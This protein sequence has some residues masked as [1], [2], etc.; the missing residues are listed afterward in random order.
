MTVTMELEDQTALDATDVRAALTAQM[1]AD[2]VVVY[3]VHDNGA[4]LVVGFR[5]GRGVC[6]WDLCSDEAAV[7]SGGNNEDAL[8]Y[9]RAQIAVPPGSEVD[10]AAV[11][12]A[13]TEFVA[14]GERP[15]V[16]EWQ[17]YDEAEFP[18]AEP[19]ITPEAL[20]EL[21]SKSGGPGSAG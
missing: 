6:L 2:H 11:L 19:T 7:T 5:G 8:M 16:V 18:V 9:G 13:A 1:S 20:Q 21:L 10:A 15:T 17:L 3:L 14:T 4:E 12:D